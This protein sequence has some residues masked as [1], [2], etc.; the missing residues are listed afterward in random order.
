MACPEIGQMNLRHETHKS[1][2]TPPMPSAELKE[3]GGPTLPKQSIQKTIA[4]RHAHVIAS[5]PATANSALSVKPC[6]IAQ[7]NLS[8]NIHG[9]QSTALTGQHLQNQKLSKSEQS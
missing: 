1:L 8:V 7:A 3:T 6:S 4:K 5:I 9:N 2:E